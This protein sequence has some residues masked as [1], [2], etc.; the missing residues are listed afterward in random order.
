MK[1]IDMLEG[2]LHDARHAL[3]MLRKKPGFSVAAILT[4]ALGIGATT[5]IFSVVNGILIRPLPYPNADRL[6]GVYA[7]GVMQGRPI[8]AE[9]SPGMYASYQQSG[10]TFQEFGV[11]SGGTATVT[12][13]GEPEEIPIVTLTQGVLLA[14]GVEPLLGRWFSKQGDTPG[15]PPTIILSYDYWQR[16]FGG[17]RESIGRTVAIDSE[18]KQIVG[19]MPQ[20]F[21]S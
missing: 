20:A 18:L 17:Y 4:L 5:A 6:I 15:S 14:L 13:M 8:R 16:K 3:R 10:Q 1:T 19:I 7:S 21:D 12:G 2:V 11:W 9:L